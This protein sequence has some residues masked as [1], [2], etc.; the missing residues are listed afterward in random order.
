MTTISTSKNTSPPLSALQLQKIRISKTVSEIT[1][2]F[3]LAYEGIIS[4]FR[5]PQLRIWFLWSFLILSGFLVI[6]YILTHYLIL[7]PLK[8]LQ[9]SNFL[10]SYISHHD[11]NSIDL[12]L[13]KIIVSVKGAIAATPFVG[14]LFVRYL[15]PKPL[16][17][18]FMTSLKTSSDIYFLQLSQFPYHVDYW[19]EMKRYFARTIRRLRLLLTVYILSSI[20]VLGVWVTPLAS[21]WLTSRALGKP[22]AYT[23]ALASF[24]FP[25]F[26]PYSV[27][28]L[29]YFYGCRALAWELL[30]PY[31]CRVVVTNSERYQ[32]FLPNQIIT[33][34]FSI[35]FYSLMYIPYIGPCFFILGQAAVPTLLIYLSDSPGTPF[36]KKDDAKSAMNVKNK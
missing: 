15:Y 9:W 33:L 17:K 27:Y 26:K 10:L 30:E 11:Y 8:I 21:A 14:L 36:I 5:N 16:D 31:F 2:G 24:L 18:V 6:V 35:I 1:K 12:A 3:K 7:L 29:S 32:W 20:P 25:S 19:K 13:S 4:S 22:L 34:S 28:T 23:L